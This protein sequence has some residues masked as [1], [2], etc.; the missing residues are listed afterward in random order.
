MALVRTSRKTDE[1][2]AVNRVTLERI[3]L[4]VAGNK[5]AR[6]EVVDVLTPIIQKHVLRVLLRYRRAAGGRDIRQEMEDLTQ[7]VLLTLFKDQG[8]ELCRWNPAQG[9]AFSTFIGI[10][11]EREI[12]SILRSKRRNPW[13]EEPI[14]GDEIDLDDG[15]SSAE[16]Q[17]ASREM[18]EIIL[19]R[20]KAQLSDEGLQLFHMILIDERSVE[21]VCAITSKKPDAVYQWRAR[22]LGRVRKIA[23]EVLSESEAARRMNEGS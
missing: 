13:T 12:F 9:G 11:T 21:D 14:G 19:D 5:A 22:L 1:T 23:E 3:E 8:R 18:Y 4:A 17:V 16:I 2:S 15:R 7:D 6:R 20:L 10:V